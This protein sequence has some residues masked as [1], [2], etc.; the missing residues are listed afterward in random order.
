M[1]RGFDSQPCR[2]IIGSS[3]RQGL[4]KWAVQKMRC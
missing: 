4:I 3:R 2:L 1:R